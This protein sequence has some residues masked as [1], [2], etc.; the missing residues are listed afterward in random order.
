MPIIRKCSKSGA[1]IFDP[2]PEEKALQD[3]K[4]ELEA[5]KAELKEKLEVLDS[6]IGEQTV[7]VA[8]KKK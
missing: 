5:M 4:N 2:T 8:K 3:T 7:S 6:I 1:L